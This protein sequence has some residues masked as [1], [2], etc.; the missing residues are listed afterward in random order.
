MKQYIMKVLAVVLLLAAFM[1]WMAETASAE[2]TL[3]VDVETGI[4]GKVKNGKAFP[5]TLTIKNNGEDLSGDLVISS[6]PH[7]FAYENVVVPVEIAAGA[8]QNIQVSLPGYGDHMGANPMNPSKTKEIRFYDGGWKE[9]DEIKISGDTRL[10]PGFIPD[11]KLVLGV[12]SDNP[13][14]MNVLKLT[15]FQGETPEVLP[16][17]E[18][19]LPEDSLGLGMFNALVIHDYAIGQLPEKKQAALKE[20]VELGGHLIIGSTPDLQQKMGKLASL[21]PMNVTGEKE[22]KD[23]SFLKGYSDKPLALNEMTILTGE[24]SAGADELIV[25]SGLPLA[26]EKGL[27]MGKVTQLTYNLAEEPLASWE[28]NNGWW[29][30]IL[31]ASV[32]SQMQHPMSFYDQVHNTLLNT[33][34]LFASSFLPVS[35]IVLLFAAYIIIIVPVLYFI[36]KKKDKREWGWWIIPSIAIVTSIAIFATGASDRSG[37]ESINKVSIVSVSEEGTGSGYHISSMLSSSGGDYAVEFGSEVLHPVPFSQEFVEQTNYS[38][39][40]MVQ[41]ADENSVVTFKDVEFWSVRSIMNQVASVETGRIEG[42]LSAGDTLISGTVTNNMVHD[43]EHVYIL[44]GGSAYEVGSLAKGENKKVEIEKK[45]T[46]LIG[47]P[48]SLVADRAFPGMQNYMYGPGPGMQQNNGDDWKKFNLLRFALDEKMYNASM[49]TPLIIGYSEDSLVDMKVNGKKANEDSLNLFLQPIN[50]KTDNKGSFTLKSDQLEPTV[51]VVEGMIY[52]QEIMEG[53]FFIDAEP[54]TYDLAF[55]LP[56]SVVENKVR[57]SKLLLA[58]NETVTNDGVS[59]MN[60]KTGEAEELETGVRQ[61]KFDEDIQKYIDKDG[62]LIVRIE[63]RG[64]H[65]P[66]VPVPGVT[67]EGEFVQ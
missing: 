62:R 63:K 12:L 4:N 50:I 26:V 27:G 35:V 54:G 53:K 46:A 49:N 56:D 48:S 22:L 14:Q 40:P 30:R 3:D 32:D 18:D 25:E 7:Y 1:P 57:Y 21:I 24:Q 17:T 23:L 52:H 60:M 42:E 39:Y 29:N 44:A 45:S 19:T 16:L 6:S 41:A 67:I 58:F 61:I 55:Q 28:G 11:M 13:D 47:A 33:T 38:D 66:Q 65:N 36:L 5:V 20:W 37:G 34:E 64:Q 9:G 15:S 43:L 51:S 10:S 59:I 8:E 31:T 2:G